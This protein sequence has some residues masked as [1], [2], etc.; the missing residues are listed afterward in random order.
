MLAHKLAAV[1]AV[2]SLGVAGGHY[3]TQAQFNQLQSRVKQVEVAQWNMNVQL[4]KQ[5]D[6]NGYLVRYLDCTR[7]VINALAAGTAFAD[8]GSCKEIGVTVSLPTG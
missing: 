1:A 2:S 4:S 5:Q 3:V 8:D 6:Y 7:L